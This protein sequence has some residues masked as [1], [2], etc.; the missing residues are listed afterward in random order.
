MSKVSRVAMLE[1]VSENRHFERSEAIRGAV[2]RGLDRLGLAA[3]AMMQGDFC[4]SWIASPSARNDETRK[5]R[6]MTQY[7]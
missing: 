4:D 7:Y 5:R 1:P 3:S 6:L 2:G